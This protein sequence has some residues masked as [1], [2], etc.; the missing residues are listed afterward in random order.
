MDSI[1]A[2]ELVAAAVAGQPIAYS[3]PA[4][5]MAF[6]DLKVVDQCSIVMVAKLAVVAAW[7]A[8]MLCAMPAMIVSLT[9]PLATNLLRLS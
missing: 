9:N 6:A 5:L 2:T 4:A 1:C 8:E 3:Q 7:G